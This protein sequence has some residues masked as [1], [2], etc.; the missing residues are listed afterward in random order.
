MTQRGCCKV[1][2]RGW[3]A[4]TSV[5]SDRAA[6]CAGLGRRGIRFLLSNSATPR[7]RDLYRAFEQ[8]TVRAPRSINCKGG[9]RGRVDEL[10]VFNG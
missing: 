7:V 3:P 6:E 10:L 9:S 8:R 2:S 5:S 4:G 1:G